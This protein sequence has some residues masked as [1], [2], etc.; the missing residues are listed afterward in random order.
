MKKDKRFIQFMFDKYKFS[1]N[2]I[3]NYSEIIDF[4][5]SN[6]IIDEAVRIGIK[7]AGE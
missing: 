6:K 1:Q 2:K 5:F 4:I 7:K 3:Y